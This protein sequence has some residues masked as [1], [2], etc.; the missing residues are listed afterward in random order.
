MVWWNNKFTLYLEDTLVCQ[1]VRTFRKSQFQDYCIVC[2]LHTMKT[3]APQIHIRVLSRIQ[4]S[5]G[6]NRTSLSNQLRR[7]TKRQEAIAT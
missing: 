4:V 3:E 7:M 1:E 5:F 6:Y 2:H